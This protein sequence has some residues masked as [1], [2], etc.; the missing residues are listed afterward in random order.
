MYEAFQ[1]PNEL[2]PTARL[3]SLILQGASVEDYE[4][5]VLAQ[6]YEVMHS[7]ILNVLQDAQLYADHAEHKELTV[8]DVKLA[9]ETRATLDF[10][11]PPSRQKKNS[12]P[13]PLVPEKL[14]LRLPPERHCLIR[15]NISINPKKRASIDTV[16]IS[17]KPA[18]AMPTAMPGVPMPVQPVAINSNIANA[19]DDYDME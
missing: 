3:I 19:D 7:Y 1:D 14:G 13:L 4:P 16:Q 15:N 2:P 9:I 8:A 10:T 5:R 12:I 17:K 6:L 11:N 18:V